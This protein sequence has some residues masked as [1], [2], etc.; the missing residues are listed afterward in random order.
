MLTTLFWDQRLTYFQKITLW[1][2]L[3]PATSLGRI[4]H[5]RG[6]QE[7][8]P[9]DVRSSTGITR[10]HF[11]NV[12]MEPWVR[13]SGPWMLGPQPMDVGNSHGVTGAHPEPGL[14][15]LRC[16]E[17]RNDVSARVAA[18]NTLIPNAFLGLKGFTMKSME[19]LKIEY[20]QQGI[21]EPPRVVSIIARIFQQS[22][23]LPD[24]PSSC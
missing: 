6:F 13:E 20:F 9:A 8:I 7:L 23:S 11:M 1:V 17:F 16:R 14:T 2:P 12:I 19:S 10:E 15:S 4:Q 21:Y 3:V 18:T 24:K 5:R 22:L